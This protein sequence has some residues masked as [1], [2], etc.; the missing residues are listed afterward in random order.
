MAIRMGNAPSCPALL[1]AEEQKRGCPWA[2]GIRVFWIRVWQSRPR[3]SFWDV[4]APYRVVAVHFVMAHPVSPEALLA[5]L[6]KG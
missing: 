6:L 4:P 3:G 5:D 2:M 1:L